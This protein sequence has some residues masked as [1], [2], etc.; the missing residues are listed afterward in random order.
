MVATATGFWDDLSVLLRLLWDDRKLFMQLSRRDTC[1][2][3]EL[4]GIF[5]SMWR[6]VT[7]DGSPA[8]SDAEIHVDSESESPK[9]MLYELSLRYVLVADEYQRA[10][11]FRVIANI[12]CGPEWT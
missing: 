2:P 4:S 1:V 12:T 3:Y 8:N 5:F 7:Q 10:A 6:F 11:M 9:S